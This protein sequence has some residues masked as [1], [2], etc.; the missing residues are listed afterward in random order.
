MPSLS[1]AAHSN[2]KAQQNLFS[3]AKELFSGTEISLLL[4][5][6]NAWAI[7]I[8]SRE[9]KC[10]IIEYIYNYITS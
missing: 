4:V 3:E 7:R 5:I 6:A 1:T 2:Q 8:A 9:L 10:Q